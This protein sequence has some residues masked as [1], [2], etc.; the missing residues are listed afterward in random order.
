MSATGEIE[1]LQNEKMR[2]EEESRSLDEEIK[3][4]EMRWKILGERVAIQQLKNENIAKKEII[5][6]LESKIGLLET[7]LEK[8][9]TSGVLK[10]EDTTKSETAE[11]REF[12]KETR[13]A[14]EEE[15]QEEE[16]FIRVMA[17][18]NGEKIN[19]KVGAEQEKESQKLFY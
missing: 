6:Q 3:Q 17:L 19:D 14:S 11:R 13:V 8:L 9:L 4:L 10:K 12:M 16:E 18:D 15:A 1:Q 7:R 5:G 2:L